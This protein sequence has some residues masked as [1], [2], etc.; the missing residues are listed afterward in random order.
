MGGKGRGLP[1]TASIKSPTKEPLKL[2]AQRIRTLRKARSLSQEDLAGRSN[3]SV[4]FISQIERCGTNPSLDTLHRLA[5]GFGIGLAELLAFRPLRTSRESLIEEIIG[6]AKRRDR[7]D[8]DLARKIL[9][10]LLGWL[11]V[12]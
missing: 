4:K 5:T 10:D 6:L 11:E 3:L 7:K 8:L 12:D 2:L 1:Y 9:E